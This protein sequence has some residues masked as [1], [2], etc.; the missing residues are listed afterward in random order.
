MGHSVD[1]INGVTAGIAIV[2][3]RPNYS[4]I[5]VI[6]AVDANVAP[7]PL[8]KAS[9][10]GPSP[11]SPSAFFP[12]K[13]SARRFVYLQYLMQLVNRGKWCKLEH[14]IYSAFPSVTQLWPFGQKAAVQR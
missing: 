14:V 8:F 10:D 9:S 1:M 11:A 12:P 6:L 13:P 5:F 2:S 4:V 7:S 3:E